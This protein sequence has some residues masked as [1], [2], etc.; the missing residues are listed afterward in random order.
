ML[1]QSPVQVPVK[2]YFAFGMKFQLE[3]VQILCT[4]GNVSENLHY[5]L[6]EM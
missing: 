3:A 5:P 6:A 2:S 1:S 4:S